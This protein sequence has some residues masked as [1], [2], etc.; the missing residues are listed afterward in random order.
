MKNKSFSYK[1]PDQNNLISFIHFI[2]RRD[3]IALRTS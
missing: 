2:E 1:Y 3:A